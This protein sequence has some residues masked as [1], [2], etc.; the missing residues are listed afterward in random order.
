[1][2][3]NIKCAP[4]KFDKENNTCY[5]LDQIRAIVS[6]Y[7]AYVSNV[8]LT[9]NTN[10]F[11][12]NNTDLIKL[13]KNKRQMLSDLDS[14]FKNSCKLNS[15]CFTNQKFMSEIV[16]FM[17]DDILYNTFRPNGPNGSVEWLNTTHIN[18]IM[19]Q[20]E[21]YYTNFKFMG[22]IPLDCASYNF[23]ALSKL[24]FKDFI[25]NKIDNVGVIYNHDRVGESGSHWVALFISIQTQEVNYCD[26]TGNGILPEIQKLVDKFQN[27]CATEYKKDSIFKINKIKYQKDNSECGVY[28]CNFIIRRLAGESF[29]SVVNNNLSFKQ[30]NSCRNAYFNKNTSK[31][32]VH[33]KCDVLAVKQ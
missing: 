7:N 23:C 8:K 20:Y 16:A 10:K 31:Y 29:E 11:V 1:M 4:G 21:K 13:S 18:D 17:H 28:S 2:S 30:I 33:D 25:K 5:N 14:Q 19:A 12:N 9:D 3:D 22:A 32:N 24:D 15:Q 6:A 27:F 26:S